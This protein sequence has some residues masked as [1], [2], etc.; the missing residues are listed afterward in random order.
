MRGRFLVSI[1]LATLVCPPEDAQ[2]MSLDITAHA[3]YPSY[4]AL[5]TIKEGCF[6]Y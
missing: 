4:A 1:A 6:F 2:L 3:S 5:I